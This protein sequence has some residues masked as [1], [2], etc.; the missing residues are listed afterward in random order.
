[1]DKKSEDRYFEIDPVAIATRLI[2]E[3]N[4]D[5]LAKHPFEGRDRL[6]NSAYLHR[7]CEIAIYNYDKFPIDKLSRWLGFIQGMM[8]ANYRGTIDSH[9]DFTRPLFHKAYEEKGM[10]VPATAS[11]E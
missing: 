8:I 1:M 7:M 10:V 2:L 6:P 4:R 9:R 11:V 3:K 5:V